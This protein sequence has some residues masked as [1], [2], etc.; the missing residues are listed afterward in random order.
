MAGIVGGNM[1]ASIVIQVDIEDIDF[2][3]LTISSDVVQ[4]E[5]WGQL[6]THTEW[7]CDWDR[8]MYDGQ[9]VEVL[10]YDE[11]VTYLLDRERYGD[12]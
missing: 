12:V 2:Q 5:A 4:T 3:G 1:R 8:A 7:E 11:A 9:E 10:D 6:A